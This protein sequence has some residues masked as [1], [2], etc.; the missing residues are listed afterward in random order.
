MVSIN[1]LSSRF[2]QIFGGDF[3]RAIGPQSVEAAPPQTE[4][5]PVEHS[6]HPFGD[7]FSLPFRRRLPGHGDIFD[8]PRKFPRPTLPPQANPMGPVGHIRPN[9]APGAL[10]GD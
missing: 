9:G 6:V 10:G 4:A 7:H 2:S 1:S 5:A 8:V 3:N